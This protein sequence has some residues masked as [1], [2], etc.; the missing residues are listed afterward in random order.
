[1]LVVLNFPF[2]ILL[3]LI[4]VAILIFSLWSGQRRGLIKTISGILILAL[5]FCG[6]GFLAKSTA[7]GI[8]KSFVEPYV[9]DFLTPK[10]TDADT[11]NAFYETL[12]N[13]GVPEKL[14]QQI[15]DSSPMSDILLNATTTLSEKLTF[16]ILCLL[17]FIV[18]LIV[19]KLVFKLLDHIF[20]LPVLNFIN[21]LGGLIFG[22]IW[23]YLLIMLLGTIFLNVG[24]F[25]DRATLSQTYIL[26]FIISTNPFSLI[27]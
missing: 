5:A 21:G 15:C 17:Y 25:F 2:P 24:L 11:P 19:L 26:N 22:G 20:D 7:P 23:G 9:S 4:V 27:F 3:D 10:V 1:M 8:S 6:A 14:A 12:L 13:I 18:L 16:G